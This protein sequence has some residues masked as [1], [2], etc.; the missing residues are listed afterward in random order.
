[1]GLQ[2]GTILPISAIVSEIYGVCERLMCVFIG[3]VMVMYARYVCIFNDLANSG[4]VVGVNTYQ[5]LG[6]FEGFLD[7]IVL[8]CVG[9]Y[10]VCLCGMIRLVVVRA[11]AKYGEQYLVVSCRL[12]VV[13]VC[14]CCVYCVLLCA[15]LAGYM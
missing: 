14:L 4:Y 12:P 10:L 8:F 9:V 5:Y 11:M 7:M 6:Y 2:D 1:M 15:C 3:C 13:S